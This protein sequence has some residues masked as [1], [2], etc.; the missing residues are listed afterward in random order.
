[1]TIQFSGRKTGVKGMTQRSDN[2]V[3]R[4]LAPSPQKQKNRTCLYATND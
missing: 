4:D 1:M 3:A 2:P